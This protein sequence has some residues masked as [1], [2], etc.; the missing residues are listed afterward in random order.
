MNNHEGSIPFTRSKNFDHSICKIIF[1]VQ[2]PT[3]LPTAQVKGDPINPR[4]E[5]CR[6][7]RNMRR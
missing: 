2:S 6:D 5:P 1:D 7:G 3:F 4:L